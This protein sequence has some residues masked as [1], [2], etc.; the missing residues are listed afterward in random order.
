MFHMGVPL[1]STPAH[2]KSTSWV[3]DM[4]SLTDGQRIRDCE[5]EYRLFWGKRP[6]RP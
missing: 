5:V 2:T 1:K 6:R 4:Y 3:W